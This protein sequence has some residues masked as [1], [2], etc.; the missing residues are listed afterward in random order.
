[1]VTIRC[2][3]HAGPTDLAPTLFDVVPALGSDTGTTS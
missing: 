1:M 2:T 3:V